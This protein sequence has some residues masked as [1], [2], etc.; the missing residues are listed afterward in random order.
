MFALVPAYKNFMW[1]TFDHLRIKC[2]HNKA[3]F[4]HKSHSHYSW[5]RAYRKECMARN[6]S[7]KSSQKFHHLWSLLSSFFA[8]PFL[9]GSKLVSLAR[10][11]Y[12]G[13]YP[14]T[15]VIG[16]FPVASYLLSLGMVW[17]AG[18]YPGTID[19][20]DFAGDIPLDNFTLGAFLPDRD[21]DGFPETIKI[22]FR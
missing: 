5:H 6:T 14:G 13:W 1:M 20:G 8:Q 19:A 4:P 10:V 7:K 21:D 3:V 9:D 17:Y 11:W 2:R 18:W 12:S 15:A 22:H 16:A